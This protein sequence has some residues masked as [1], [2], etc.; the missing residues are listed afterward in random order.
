MTVSV[1][2]VPVTMLIDSGSTCNIINAEYKE[3]L[4]Q[5][6]GKLL[7]CNRKI[8]SYSSLPIRVHQ[9]I[10]SNITLEDGNEIEAV[11]GTATPMLGKATTGSLGLLKIGVC[12]VT[13]YD[14]H[15]DEV[16][17]SKTVERNWLSEGRASKVAHR[18]IRPSSSSEA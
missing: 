6:G 14:A 1:G 17:V 18:L 4:I 11:E 16:V 9:L 13:A 7:S 3:K 15:G 12:H 2:N 10:R 5:Q 8:H